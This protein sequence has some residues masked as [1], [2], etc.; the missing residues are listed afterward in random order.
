MHECPIPND[1]P[2]AFLL[3]QNRKLVEI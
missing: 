1:L 2:Y 3:I